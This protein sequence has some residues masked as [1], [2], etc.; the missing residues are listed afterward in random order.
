MECTNGYSPNKLFIKF[1]LALL[2][3]FGGFGASVNA[4]DIEQGKQIYFDNG[5]YSC[6]GYQGKGTFVLRVN[7]LTPVPPVL[8]KGAAPFLGSE[9]LFR[10]YL[11]LRG[12]QRH[13]KPSV[14]MPHYPASVIDDNDVASL[15]A[16]IET[17]T[18]DDPELEDISSM[19][20]ILDWEES[21]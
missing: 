18:D 7:I 11:R 14:E 19:Q 5:C 17:F 12:E 20:W 2:I 8:V 15:Y 9:E 6:H 1:A 3:F 13:D 16:Y 10:T 4:Q 21:R